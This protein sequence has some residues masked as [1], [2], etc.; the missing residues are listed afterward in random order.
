METKVGFEVRE[1]L[2]TCPFSGRCVP[3]LEDVLFLLTCPSSFPLP[4]RPMQKFFL[5]LEKATCPQSTPS[6]VLPHGKGDLSLC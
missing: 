5:D 4:F 6:P 2:S 3:F 1:A